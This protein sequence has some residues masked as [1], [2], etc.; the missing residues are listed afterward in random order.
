MKCYDGH[1][2]CYERYTVPMVLSVA[3]QQLY[4]PPICKGELYKLRFLQMFQACTSFL[5]SVFPCHLPQDCPKPRIYKYWGGD[6]PAPRG[7]RNLSPSLYLPA[8]RYHHQRATEQYP[9]ELNLPISGPKFS[10]LLTPS[11]TQTVSLS[12][13][14]RTS[15]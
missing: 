15:R 5:S 1:S 6:L 2:R 3:Q 14:R 10:I 12:G 4:I 7:C 11:L 8:S 13:N 9:Q